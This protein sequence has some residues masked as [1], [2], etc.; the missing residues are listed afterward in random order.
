MKEQD[1]FL[2]KRKNGQL[3]VRY[4]FNDQNAGE[5]QYQLINQE[6]F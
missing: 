3:S 1:K 5:K 2:Q 6:I 4:I